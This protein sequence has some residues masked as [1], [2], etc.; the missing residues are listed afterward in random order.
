[1]KILL[2]GDY[3][4]V[5]YE[6][7]KCLKS[8]G[9]DVTLISDGDAYKEIPAD[10]IISNDSGPKK[11]INKIFFY[12]FDF[13]GISGILRYFREVKYIELDSFDVIQIINP[14]VIPQFG[15]IGNFLFIRNLKNRSKNKKI[16][17][18]GLG[19]D[20]SWVKACLSKKYKYS[21]L[22]RLNIKTIGKYYYSLKYIFSPAYLLLDFYSKK[23]AK[24]IICGLTDYLIAH[25]ED[26]KA[27]FSGIPISSCKFHN[28]ELKNNKE[29]IIK[30]FHSWQK[31][32]ELKKGND[33]LNKA[34][35]ILLNKYGEKLDYVIA[36]GMTYKEYIQSYSECDIYLDQIYSYD[37][38]VSGALGMCAGK[39]VV[40][41][42][43]LLE[44]FS[45]KYSEEIKKIGVNGTPDVDKLVSDLSFLIENP[46]IIEEIKKN[47]Y[48]FSLKE[49]DAKIICERYIKIWSEL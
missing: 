18:C 24:S 20:F 35:Q 10:I 8:E 5:H 12:L 9:H 6:L 40:S 34:A 45:S 11:K 26:K 30:I 36:S 32:K 39:V 31:G 27:I 25:S 29:G 33:I 2:C 43:E 22:D 41:G 17:L 15:A 42:F 14:V 4:S 16:Y 37:R 13:F 47:A 23:N 21:P 48:E 1:M 19:D 46:K 28:P 44:P 38:G 3:S 49:Y 7:S